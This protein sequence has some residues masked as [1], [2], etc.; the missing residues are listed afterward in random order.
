MEAMLV[1]VVL[2]NGEFDVLT[3]RLHEL[4][5]LVD[6]FV[7]VEGDR[8]FSGKPKMLS[9]PT[10]AGTYRH[11]PV[12]YIVAE[13]PST[14]GHPQ[15]REDYQRYMIASHFDDFKIDPDDWVMLSDVDEIP[16]ADTVRDV[17]RAA[18]THTVFAQ[19]LYHYYINCRNRTILRWLGTRM[20]RRKDLPNLDVF[21]KMTDIAMAEH[22]GWHF[23]S[24]GGP[25]AMLTK[26]QSWSHQ[27]WNRPPYNTIEHMR[28]HVLAGNDWDTERNLHMEFVPIPTTHPKW[29]LEHLSEYKQ[30]IGGEVE[31]VACSG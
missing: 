7:I 27:E 8:T 15:Q 16:C 9:Y 17:I 31:Q 24:L 5:N 25:R 2:F 26:L 11:W 19:E 14:V 4:E 10:E 13:L 1:D 20:A 6:L 29:L 21:R 30:H 18:P 22:G 23:S 28:Q 12:K 3:W